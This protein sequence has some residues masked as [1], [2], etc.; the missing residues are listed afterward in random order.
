MSRPSRKCRKDSDTRLALARS[1][2]RTLRAG[3]PANRSRPDWRVVVGIVD[4]DEQ[5]IA[6][7]PQR[8]RYQARARA[9]GIPDRTCGIASKPYRIG[10]EFGDEKFC[11]CGY[12]LTDSPAGIQE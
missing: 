7:M 3:L 8:Q 5:A 9:L 11:R 10:D 2:N 4:F 1:E 6:E 12:A